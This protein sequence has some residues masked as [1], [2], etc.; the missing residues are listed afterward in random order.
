MVEKCDGTACL[1][2]LLQQQDVMDILAREAIRGGDQDA[3]KLAL[4]NR[5]P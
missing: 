3:I 5:F 2:E 4:G 1:L